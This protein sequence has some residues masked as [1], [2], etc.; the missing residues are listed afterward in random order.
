MIIGICRLPADLRRGILCAG[1]R[2][3]TNE[4]LQKALEKH[5][6]V[7]DENEK[8]DILV[9][10][11]CITSDEIINEFLESTLGTDLVL[12]ALNSVCSG[13]V[14]SFNVLINFIIRHIAEIEEA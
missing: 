1:L 5:K 6:N 9:G 10:L 11:G 4:T 3:A 13:N 14:A 12:D 2:T 8:T 7:T